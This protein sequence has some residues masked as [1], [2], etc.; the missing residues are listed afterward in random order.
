MFE[1]SIRFAGRRDG[2]KPSA[3]E[4]PRCSGYVSAFADTTLTNGSFLLPCGIILMK[5][6]E[7]YEA[8]VARF[9]AANSEDPNREVFGGQ[10]YPKELLYARRMTEWLE[11]LAPDASESVR[12]AARSQHLR[13]WTIPRSEYPM[14]RRGYL[15]WR[16]ALKKYHAETAADILREVGYE[17]ETIARVGALLRKEGLTHDPEMQLLEDVICLVFLESYFSDFSRKHDEAKILDILRKT[18]AKMTP[19]GHA[20]ALALA[21]TL[22][23]DDRA[24]IRKALEP[25]GEP[26]TL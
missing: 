26:E 22:P 6:H 9:D 21:A 5:N 3:G 12:L 13:R 10:E 24:L 25:P 19:R 11:R 7:R 18:W 8:A 16:T 23:L 4:P 20:A 1:G 2:L 17:E 14:D 15:R